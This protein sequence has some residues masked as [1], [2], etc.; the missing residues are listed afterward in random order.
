MQW[1][2]PSLPCFITI[3]LFKRLKP[4]PPDIPLVP[5]QSVF[6]PVQRT[7]TTAT[8]S[9]NSQPEFVSFC[10]ITGVPAQL[11]PG[12][13]LARSGN[14][15]LFQSTNQISPACRPTNLADDVRIIYPTQIFVSHGCRFS[16]KSG[17]PSLVCI[18]LLAGQNIILTQ[19]FTFSKTTKTV[20]TQHNTPSFM[21]TGE[22]FRLLY[23][24]M[25]FQML[26]FRWYGWHYMIIMNS[27]VS[28]M[29]LSEFLN[30]EDVGRRAPDF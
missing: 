24:E 26:F 7:I 22:N 16:L 25:F 30:T 27:S 13:K 28:M 20:L 19:Q 14:A 8:N 23:C 18:N 3:F 1:K 17:L 12:A 21:C 6:I 11:P 10:R 9:S 4:V 2:K 5:A 15:N 29:Y